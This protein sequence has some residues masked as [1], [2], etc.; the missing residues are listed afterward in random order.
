MTVFDEIVKR[1]PSALAGL[2]TDLVIQ[3]ITKVYS[4]TFEVDIDIPD[5]NRN[6]IYNDYY[7]SLIKEFGEV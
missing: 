4:T 2:M 5:D 3:A 7:N 1:G 6:E